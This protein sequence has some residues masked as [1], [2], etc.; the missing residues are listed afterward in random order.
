MTT[1]DDTGIFEAVDHG[2]PA[3]RRGRVIGVLVLAAALVLAG[4]AWLLLARGSDTPEMSVALLQRDAEPTDELSATVADETGVVP[5]SSR[6]AVR[7]SAGPHYAALGWDG[8]LCLVLVPEGDAPRVACVA[9]SPTAAITLAGEDGSRVRLGTDD[10]AA[11]SGTD[12]WRAAGP[13]VWV[14]DAPPPAEG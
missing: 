14:V 7:T 11:P 6:F 8:D 5:T 3:P 13:N 1:F 12:Q 4:V 9:P 2:D 10:A